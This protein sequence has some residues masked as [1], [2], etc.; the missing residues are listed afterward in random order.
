MAATTVPCCL[1]SDQRPAL[2]SHPH[3]RRDLLG[4]LAG[5]AFSCAAVAGAAGAAVVGEDPHH[6]WARD[7]ERVMIEWK[8]SPD[9]GDEASDLFADERSRI[10]LLILTTPAATKAGAL[11][12]LDLVRELLETFGGI[13]IDR[14][15]IAGL[16]HA[17]ATL[18]G[19]A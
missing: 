15:E 19:R 11:V 8:A 2:S 6:A 9:H 14:R 5:A 7:L 3:R 17:R 12:Q 16:D 4:G 10:E 1:S 13:F 18:A